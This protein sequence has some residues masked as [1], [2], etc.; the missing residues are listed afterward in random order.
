MQFVGCEIHLATAEARESMVRQL[1][2]S[3]ASPLLVLNT[4][5]RLECFGK[6]NP[7]I[8]QIPVTR[9]WSDAEAFE[10][11][12]RIAAGLESRIL[13]ELEV[14]GQ[15]RDAYRQFRTFGGLGDPS[16]DRVFQ[17][18]LSLAR[19]A[20]RESGIDRKLTSLSA[21]A[22]REML[23]S[24]P[25]GVPVVVVGSGSLAGSVTRY[26][27]KRGKTPVRVAG[28]CPV[29]AMNLAA[30]ADGFGAGLDK[31]SHLMDGAAGV[32]TAT[33]APHPVVY[34]HH[35]E[36][37]LRPLHII[38]LGVPPDCSPEV[39]SLPEVNYR[40]LEKIEALAQVNSDERRKRAELAARIIREGAQA[41][42]RKR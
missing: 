17:D 5:Q 9:M 25:D 10:R 39:L 30:C 21:L 14:L 12:A 13:G 2:Q 19:K 4:C 33:A 6:R 37:T 42:A 41:W 16:L 8:P 34:A 7:T 29:N 32:I 28:R 3:Q 1:L 31:L 18:A 20:R 11:L 27:G 23:A 26:L 38:D 15:V 35:L 36:Q 40:G 24:V 22:C